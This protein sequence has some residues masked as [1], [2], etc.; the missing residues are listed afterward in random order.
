M[1]PRI[2]IILAE[3][4]ALMRKSLIALLKE[5]SELEVVGEAGNG[6]EVLELLKRMKTDIVLMDIKMPIMSGTEALKIMQLRFPEV[7]VI[8]LSVHNDMAYIKDAIALGARGYL[9]KDC[10]PEELVTTIVNI[11]KNGFY[12]E[13]SISKHLLYDSVYKSTT[14]L[15]RQALSNRETEVLK[16]LCKGKTEKEIAAKLNISPHTVHF[17]RVNIYSKTNSHNL[18]DLLKYAGENDVNFDI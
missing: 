16:E 4:K 7:K 5:Y 12:L 17:H 3:D 18:A 13:E 1:D 9:A 8:I 15:S 10:S 6:K 2:R 11:N 14:T